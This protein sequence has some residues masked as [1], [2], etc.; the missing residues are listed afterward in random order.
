MI[1]SWTNLYMQRFKQIYFYSL[2]VFILNIFPMCLREIC[3]LNPISHNITESYFTTAKIYKKGVAKKTWSF[4][5]YNTFP[6][7]K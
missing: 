7:R 4:K 1:F 3:D 6:Q 2:S 5:F